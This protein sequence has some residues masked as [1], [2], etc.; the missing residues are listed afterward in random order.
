[1]DST[2]ALV[3]SA[4][5]IKDVIAHWA[6]DQRSLADYLLRH[7]FVFDPHRILCQL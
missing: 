1:V 5:D 4:L 3:D 6:L 2:L 7:H